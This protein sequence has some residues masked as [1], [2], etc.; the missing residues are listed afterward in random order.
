M[1]TTVI[2]DG[3]DTLWKTQPIYKSVVDEFYDILKNQGFFPEEFQ[4][5]FDSINSA[6]FKKIKLSTDRLGRA[7]V[8]TYETMCERKG[9]HPDTSLGTQL[10]VLARQIYERMPEIL[11][12]AHNTLSLLAQN[13][14]QLV[15]Y[16]GGDEKT[17]R[18]RLLKLGLDKY[19]QD[20]VIVVTKKDEEVLKHILDTAALDPANTWMVG[21]SPKF[22]IN[23]AVRLG[24]N[25]IWLYT[26]FWKSELEDITENRIFG[27]FSLNEV[28]NILS[29]GSGFGERSYVP[30]DRQANEFQ[31]ELLKQRISD[32][33]WVVGSS[34]KHD[35]NPAL[36]I[37]LNTVWM[38]TELGRNDIEPF[39]GTMFVGFS[40]EGVNSIIK[41]WSK[42]DGN[43]PNII[44]HLSP[45]D[46]ELGDTLIVD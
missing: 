44:W 41:R 28:P 7:M 42:A 9:I 38:P 3:D 13:S 16:S 8:G 20:R 24:L 12:G 43:P 1:K 34:P 17:Q 14:F 39:C 31:S 21:N 26:S 37:N 29:Y 19:F 33:T 6:L 4:P 23:P 2:F 36:G 25:C 11:E 10:V 46:G 40:Q 22:D 15:F 5:L 35:V 27:A 45:R 18:N 30:S 32:A